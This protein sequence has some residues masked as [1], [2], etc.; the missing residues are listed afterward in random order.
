MNIPADT[1]PDKHD[2]KDTDMKSASSR[3]L[4]LALIHYPV[5][6]KKG[7]TIA[8]AVTNLDL[9]DIARAAR[10]YAVSSFYVVTPLEDQQLLV[11][12]LILHWTEGGGGRYNPARRDA[13]E[14]V[15][16]ADSIEKVQADI[17]KERKRE[18]RMI[19]TSARAYSGSLPFPAFRR[20]LRD[21]R[22]CLLVFGT[23]WGISPDF[24]SAADHILE[25]LKGNSDYN[26]L[27]VRS[28]VSVILDRLLG[29][30]EIV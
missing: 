10:T 11:K 7:E 20:I 23:A 1:V 15:R 3:N 22:P 26:H 5:V 30:R 13:L 4:Y 29:D 28:A 25:P 24:I 16:I 8:S 19:V 27:S 21:D 18:P 14:T 12:K 6:N 2:A 9:H 17:R